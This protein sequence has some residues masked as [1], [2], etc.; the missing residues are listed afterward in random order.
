MLFGY[1]DENID[2]IKVMLADHETGRMHMKGV[3]DSVEARD[4]AGLVWHFSA[5]AELLAGH[6][7]KEDEILYPWMDREL[8][9]SQVGL[10]Y[11]R[12]NEIDTAANELP[13]KYLAVV[14]RLESVYCKP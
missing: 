14:D 11:A 1:F 12:F 5:Y 13:A 7:E 6:I 10:M 8:T 4:A 2:I 9:D 3:V